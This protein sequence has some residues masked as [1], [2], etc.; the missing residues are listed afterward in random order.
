MEIQKTKLKDLDIVMEIYK[1]A[2]QFMKDN[3]NPFQWGN[4]YPSRDLINSDIEKDMSYVCIDAG[5]IVGTFCLQ[6]VAEPTYEKIYNGSWLN[7]KPYVTIHRLAAISGRGVATFCI[8]WCIGNFGNVRADTHKD[9]IPMQKVFAKTEFKQCG[10]IYLADGT[11]RIAYQ[12][13]NEGP[14]IWI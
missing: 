5:E 8:N 12:N 3:G 1:K 11:E 14:V 2:R 6:S 10:T 7:D 9:N 13:N 4:N